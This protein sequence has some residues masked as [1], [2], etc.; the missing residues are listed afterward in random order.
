M[1]LPSYAVLA[2]ASEGV[3]AAGEIKLDGTMGAMFIGAMLAAVLWGTSCVQ[4]YAYYLRCAEDG[5]YFKL[6]V[7]VV[8][9]LDTAH[10]ALISHSIY[11]YVISHYANPAAL[12]SIPT[13]LIIQVEINDITA[14]LV[15]CFFIWRIWRLSHKNYLI[16]GIVLLSAISCLVFT[17]LYVH[18]AFELTS[19]AEVPKIQEL[20]ALINITAT[21]TDVLIAVVMIWL[22][23]S[24][25]SGLDRTNDIINRL[26]LF[27]INTGLLTSI[28]SVAALVSVLAA[29]QNLIYTVFFFPLGRLYTNS[30][31]ATLNARGTMRT[32]LASQEERSSKCWISMNNVEQQAMAARSK[33]PL[34]G[35]IPVTTSERIPVDIA[36]KIETTTSDDS[37]DEESLRPSKLDTKH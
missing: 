27:V 9:V 22:L 14:F 2:A 11:Y 36:V 15:Q 31:L 8:F 17:S 18:R 34:P 1:P 4:A 37:T 29:P 21:V 33:T 7:T 10:Q 25:K 16:S 6:L 13:S 24:S 32:K 5:I 12:L 23:Q 35:T 3:A 19:F 20:S 26:L 30:L 28:C